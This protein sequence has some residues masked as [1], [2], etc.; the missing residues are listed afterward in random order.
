M[1]RV[2]CTT[3][4]QQSHKQVSQPYFFFTDLQEAV[5]ASNGEVE[6]FLQQVEAEVNLHQPIYQN[7]SH[8]T[9]YLHAI[10]VAWPNTETIQ[11]ITFHILEQSR[12][13]L[14]LEGE[15]D[16]K[17]SSLFYTTGCRF[18]IHIHK[19]CH[20]KGV[21]SRAASNYVSSSMDT[22]K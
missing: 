22:R 18:P 4:P 16:Q 6:G 12:H 14:L 8:T 11:G 10:Q 1:V 21:N 3:T 13:V 2:L 20:E 19:I 5:N 7:G 15:F 9:I 17:F